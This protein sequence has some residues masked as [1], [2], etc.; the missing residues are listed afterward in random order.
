LELAEATLAALESILSTAA[1]RLALAHEPNVD[2]RV[3]SVSLASEPISIVLEHRLGRPRFDVCCLER[4]SKPMSIEEQTT[5][6]RRAFDLAVQVLAHAV[7]FKDLKADIAEL[8][9]SERAADRAGSFATAI[10]TQRT[11]LGSEPKTSI[12]AWVKGRPDSY[13]LVREVAFYSAS[14][15]SVIEPISPASD[16]P[17]EAD[18]DATFANVPHSQM[19]TLSPIRLHLWE[20]AGWCAMLF[21]TSESE[22]A[23]PFLVPVFRSAEVAGEI[24]DGWFADE[25]AG[26]LSLQVT[27]VRGI[28]RDRPHAYRVMIGPCLQPAADRRMVTAVSRLCA[29]NP[30]SPENLERFLRA[31]ISAGRYYLAPAFLPDGAPEGSV[32]KVSTERAIAMQDLRVVEAWQIGVNDFACAAIDPE[33]EPVIPDGVS[34]AP[35]LGVLARAAT[36]SRPRELDVTSA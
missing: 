35:V 36:L 18:L 33:K 2:V 3:R 11:I 25:Q 24:F 8:F 5:I 23:P 6:R 10:G 7:T 15:K 21:L 19:A 13:P 34:D 9:G 32:P 28:N 4:E 30:S 29:M 14:P 26:R 22:S 20:K 16:V 1:V 27:I 17:S 12:S 31:R